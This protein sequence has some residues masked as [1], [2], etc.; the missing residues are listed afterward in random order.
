MREIIDRPMAPGGLTR[1]TE[2][3]LG[4]EV[5]FIAGSRRD[6]INDWVG[7]KAEVRGIRCLADGVLNITLRH[8]VDQF[9]DGFEPEDLHLVRRP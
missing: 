6:W 1:A 5:E 7:T 9:T 2:F 3:Q 4:D 8:D